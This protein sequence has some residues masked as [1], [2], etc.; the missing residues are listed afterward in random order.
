MALTSLG[1]SNEKTIIKHEQTWISVNGSL[2]FTEHWGMMTDIHIRREDYFKYPFFNFLRLGAIYWV[3][4]KYPIAFGYAHNWLAPKPGLTTWQNENRIF[5][6]WSYSEKR[7]KTGRFTRL[8]LEERW[9]EAVVNDIKTGETWYSFRF[10]VLTSFEFD[11]FKNKAL[12]KL[13]VSDEVMIQFGDQIVYNTF[14]Q[15]R[16]FIGVKYAINKNTSLDCGYMNVFQQQANG[17]TYDMSHV[18]R[19]FFY[20]TPDF[21]KVAE[22]PSQSVYENTE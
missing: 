22:S 4:G 1:Q 12:P 9:R 15:N 16:F 10:R 5:Q 21:R 13:I 19:L 7:E 6:Q 11:I 17:Y 8:R 20:Y 18:I 2:R 14:D 3:S